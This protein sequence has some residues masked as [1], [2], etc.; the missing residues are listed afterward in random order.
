MDPAPR[1]GAL[2]PAHRR[3]LTRNV[4]VLSWVSFFQDAASEMLYPVLPLFLTGV[5]G[6]PVAAVGLI[7]GVA[8]ATASVM[9]VVSGRL[10]DLRRRRPMIAGGYAL[11]SIAKPLI[12]LAQAWP[13]VLVARVVDRAGKGIRTSPRDALI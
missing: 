12:G 2:A 5:L 13:F 7:E 3:G 9:K 1:S 6:A 11:S 10:A 8:E 4:R